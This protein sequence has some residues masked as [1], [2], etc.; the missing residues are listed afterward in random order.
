MPPRE[1]HGRSDI[2]RNVVEFSFGRGDSAKVGVLLEI[3]DSDGFRDEFA[4]LVHEVEPNR[5]DLELPQ[6]SI[7]Q[8]VPWNTLTAFVKEQVEAGT[9][10]DL[11]KLGAT[12]GQVVKLKKRK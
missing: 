10:I 6:P 1:P 8:S 2:V 9:V 11:K 5:N 7:A 3:L 4:R 12:V